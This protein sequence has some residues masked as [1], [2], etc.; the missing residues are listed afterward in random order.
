MGGFMEYDG[1]RAIRVLLPEQL[2]SYSLTGNGDFPR[3]SKAEIEDKSKGDAISKGVVILQTGWFVLQCITRGAQ[4]LPITELEL[5]T[6]AF[7][8][9]NFLIYVLWWNKPQNVQR[10]ARVYKKRRTEEAVDDGDV[11]TTVGPWVALG[12]ALSDLPA[13]VV[14]GPS[15]NEGDFDSWL[16]RILTWP[17][18][19]P[20]GVIFS[21]RDSVYEKRVDTFYPNVWVAGSENFSIFLVLTITMAF[22]GIHCIGWSFNFPSSIERTLWRVASLSITSVP[23]SFPLLTTLG[24]CVDVIF[25]N[26]FGN[27]CYNACYILPFS[28]YVLSRLALLLLPLLSLRSLPPTAFHVIHWTSMIPHV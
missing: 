4:G 13:V 27:F 28:L 23:I 3:I 10:A 2:Q 22:G 25:Q 1:N 8:A 20:L 24:L 16:A 6:V 12:D 15:I 14:R 11:E 18:M 7:A 21:D 17:F 19:K 26:G 5:V 9:L